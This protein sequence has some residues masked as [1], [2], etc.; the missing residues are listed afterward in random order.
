MKA[1][2]Y[3]LL[4]ITLHALII[5]ALRGFSSAELTQKPELIELVVLPPDSQSTHPQAKVAGTRQ[6]NQSASGTS[7]N[8]QNHGLLQYLPNYNF[9]AYTSVPD[10]EAYSKNSRVDNPYSEWGE[11]SET[12]GRIADYNFFRQLY[13]KV[14]TQLSY[15]GVLARNKIMGVV[16]TRLVFDKNG[17]CNWRYTKINGSQA[18]LQLYVLDLLKRVCLQN[19]KP[20]LGGREQTVADLAFRFDINEN[21]DHDR[22]EAQKIVI[23]NVLHFY[24]NSHQSIMEW[25]LGP[26]RGMFPVPMVYL[27][28]PWI[29][30]NW[31]RIINKKDPLTEFKKQFGG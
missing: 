4:S 9:D 18:Y 13:E 6:G 16:Q 1:L 8:S 28:I 26:F 19:F 22:V 21:D 5:L 25:E 20:M 12:F 27:N 30:E 15:P 23:G 17:D 2:R 31:D 24:R 7:K 3:L 11:G 14:D 29:Q 10:S